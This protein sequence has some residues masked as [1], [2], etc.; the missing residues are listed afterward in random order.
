MSKMNKWN[1]GKNPAGNEDVHVRFKDGDMTEANANDL[2]WENKDSI[3]EWILCSEYEAYMEK[4]SKFYFD[5]FMKEHSGA[6]CP[7]SGSELHEEVY[8]IMRNGELYNAPANQLEW[9]YKNDDNNE[10][11]IQKWCLEYDY[12]KFLDIIEEQIFGKAED[13]DNK[14]TCNLK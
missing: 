2:D 1:G 13:Y 7:L 12:L 4:S 5:N 14:L 9:E 10:G 8:V 6:S 3:V 11:N